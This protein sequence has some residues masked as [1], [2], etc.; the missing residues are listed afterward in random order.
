MAYIDKLD[1]KIKFEQ[2]V[3]KL[4]NKLTKD[5]GYTIT[6]IYIIDGK[7]NADWKPLN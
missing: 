5:T 3:E 1:K 4:I 2:A 6:D 7:V